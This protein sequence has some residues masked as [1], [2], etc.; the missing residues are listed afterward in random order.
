MKTK[1]PFKNIQ[2]RVKLFLKRRP[3]R[4]LKLTR[5]RD[6]T[7]SLKLPGNIAFTKYVSK[8]IWKN[9]KLF[10]MLALF[11]A[12]LTVFMVG[13]ASQDT[14]KTLVDT[15]NNTSGNLFSSGFGEIGKAGLLFVTAAT[16][17]LSQNLTDI[18]Q[19]YTG[20]ITILTWLT[21]VWL[22]RNI[23]AGHKI[24]LRDGLYNAGSPI[25]ATFIVALVFLVQLL[26]IAL[27]IIGYTAASLTGLL[28]SG[29]EA[30]LF[31][32]VAA[33]LATLSMYWITS[34]LFALVIVT[35]PGMYP[36]KALKT[37]GDL[38]VG[39]RFRILLRFVWMMFITVLI[40]AITMIPLILLDKWI[41]GLW[42]A[43]SWLPTIPVVLLVL[44]AITIVWISSYVYL[45]YRKVIADDAEP[46]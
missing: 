22:L 9:R 44:G 4:T 10:A 36:F 1:N 29:I 42:S 39:R 40:W 24:K 46:A 19:V 16:G 15:L 18:Q 20:I 12:I 34:T 27:A 8:T 11:Y 43:I 5:H 33:L 3:H 32:V 38:V 7:R 2:K 37:A 30:M 17:G 26:P 35:L 21:S 13:I 45:L 28:D 41:K 25:V 6:Y 14:Y 23:L 31:W